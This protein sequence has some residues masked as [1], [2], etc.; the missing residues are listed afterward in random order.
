MAVDDVLAL[1]GLTDIAER[2][3]EKLS[4]GQTQRVRFAL[5]I[6][7]NP[8]LLVLDEPTV[9]LDVEGRRDFWAS[10]RGF[11]QSGKTIVFATHYLEEADAFAD[12]II[13]MAHGRIVA[14]GPTG[15]IKARVGMKTIKATLPDVTADGLDR[16][17]GV[18]VDE[19][20]ALP[21]VASAELHGET[22]ILTCNDSDTALRALL[23]QFPAARDIEVLGA[24]LE[25][26]FLA[27]TGDD[28]T[29]PD[30]IPQEALR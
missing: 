29:T 30:S 21:G 15:E 13:L 17:P 25:T 2:R 6:V 14:D 24:N 23:H 20:T 11:A 18:S 9:A 5:A 28:P 26:A 27:L 19:L 8:D 4:G 10:M 1:T 22:A 7:A 3:T 16:L 12:R